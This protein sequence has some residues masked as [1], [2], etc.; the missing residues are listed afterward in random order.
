[1]AQTPNE[2][3]C[4]PQKEQ[5]R[6]KQKVW[7]GCTCKFSWSCSAIPAGGHYSN[8][9]TTHTHAHTQPH[10]E[11]R[12]RRKESKDIFMKIENKDYGR[13]FFSITPGLGC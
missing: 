1:M 7:R 11:E 8:R 6:G 2:S 9:S 13:L 3:L 12:D 5:I 10:R 4:R